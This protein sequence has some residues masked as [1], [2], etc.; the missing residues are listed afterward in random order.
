[1]RE[2]NFDGIVGPTHNYAGLSP[3]NLASTD[4]A[5]QI[6]NPRD[7][8][9]QGLEKMR[10]V[11][12]LGA[13][14]AVLPPHP[15][16]DVDTLRR[17]GFTGDDATL[18]AR[19]R[20]AAP[21]LLRRCSSAS[22]MWTANAA[23]VAPS[24]DTLDGR[25]HLVPANLSSMFHRSLEAPVT[26]QV[27]R[28]VFSNPRHFAVHD[29]LPSGEAFADEGAANHTRLATSR[30]ALHLFGWGRRAWGSAVEPG[31]FMA[32]QTLEASQAVARLLELPEPSCVFWQ[33]DPAGIDAGA[34]HSDVLAVGHQQFLMLHEL[35]FVDAKALLE[36]LRSLLGAELCAVLALDRELPV[37]DA[38]SA[39]PFNSE[40]V[41]LPSG[42]MAIV[43]P[44]ESQENARVRAF[45][46]RVVSEDNPV[47][48]T[49]FID[50]NA[51]MNNGGGPACLRLRVAL[52]DRE[53][54][55]LGARVVWDEAL[56]VELKSW[57][58]RH[59]RDRIAPDDLVDPALLGEVRGALDELTRILRLGSVY[60]FQ[61]A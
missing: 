41:T 15:R 7:A 17:L 30:V 16:P 11:A 24:A 53:Q 55:A 51:S 57:I 39:Y 40:L 35:A 59:Y 13:P 31:R 2:L 48:Q 14:Q 49:H 54:A 19:A 37:A 20:A 43:A 9:L 47:E 50:V 27:L 46:E 26:T 42:T 1:M 12:S 45:F 36:R 52:S 4:H 25:V 28:A 60:D 8:A 5:G 58:E 44:R 6:G 10:F 21:A 33:Q 29:A 23:T 32:R 56:Y 61:R 18:L 22:A 34:F 38:V 3:G